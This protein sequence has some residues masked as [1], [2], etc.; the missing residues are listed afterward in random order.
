MSNLSVGDPAPEFSVLAHNG[1]EVK[2]SDYRGKSVLLWFYPKADTP[3]CTREGCGFRDRLPAFN[4]KD[5]QIFGVSFDT[6]EENRAFAEK[7][8]YNF[9]LLCDTKREIGMAYG[10]CDEPT[11][12]N[13]K[14]ISYLI[15][16]DGNIKHSFGKVDATN[17]PEEALALL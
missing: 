4:Q 6:V 2:L 5:V 8:D 17:H 11:A 13:A 15:G 14:R 1:Q 16:P 10:A 9:P 7:F 3:G 12:S